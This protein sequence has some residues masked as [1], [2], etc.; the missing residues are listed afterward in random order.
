MTAIALCIIAF[1]VCWA[2]GR[3]SLGYGLATL[4]A[5]G[6]SYGLLRANLLTTFSHFIFDAGLIGLYCSQKWTATGPAEPRQLAT[7]RWWVLLLICWPVLLVFMPFQPLLVSIVGLRGHIFFIPVVILGSRFKE[8]DLVQ[9]SSGLAVLN[10]VALAFGLGEYVLGVQRFYPYSSVTQIIYASG[11]VAGGYLRIPAIFTSAHAY[12]GT[13]VATLPYLVGLWERTESR[14]FRVLAVSGIAAAFL[15]VLLSATRSNFLVAAFIVIVIIFTNR[16][17]TSHRVVFIVLIAAL[18]IVALRNERFQ[19]FKSLGDTEGVEGRLAGSVNRD[20]FEILTEYPMGNGLGGGGTSIPY[21]LAGQVR[22]PIGM[23]NEYALIL[24][25]QGI[26]GL[27]LWLSFIAWFLFQ[28]RRAFAAGPWATGRRIAWSLATF[29]LATAW[30]GTGL[31]TSIP[32]TVMQLLAMGWTA[33]VAQP[34]PARWQGMIGR[35]NI[36]N[37]RKGRPGPVVPETV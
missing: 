16:M 13:M 4:L 9:L 32:G 15:G 6:Y 33:G 24:A 5:V 23:E 28:F 36:S 7:I 12:G 14:W 22:N 27:M 11:D 18:A 37:R 8:K 26:V 19:R 20:F 2:V 10:L 29:W 25:E 21:F 35:T 17:K 31:F 3:R 1:I 34:K 30:I